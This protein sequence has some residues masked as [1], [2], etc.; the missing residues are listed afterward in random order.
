[1]ARHY[2]QNL[3]KSGRPKHG[4]G[5]GA[6]TIESKKSDYQKWKEVS[7][8]IPMPKEEPIPSLHEVELAVTNWL[9]STGASPVFGVPKELA[10]YFHYPAGGAT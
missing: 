8:R 3:P 6:Y 9:A 2:V 7:E 4:K 5:A 1:M 10:R